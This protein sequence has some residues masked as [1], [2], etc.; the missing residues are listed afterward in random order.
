MF[1]ST[2]HDVEA[3]VT[4]ATINKPTSHTGQ[5]TTA[6][7]CAPAQERFNFNT[8]Q[9]G[10]RVFYIDSFHGYDWFISI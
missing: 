8:Q 9:V 5:S 1:S 6:S 10:V 4:Y 2:G 7:T 3:D